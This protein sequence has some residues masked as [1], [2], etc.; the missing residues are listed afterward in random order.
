MNKNRYRIIFNRARGLMMAV[1][2]IATGRGTGC[3]TPSSMCVSALP[4]SVSLARLHPLAGSI[5]LGLGL[6][7]VLNPL[8]CAQ[9]VADTTAPASQQPIVTQAANGVPLVNIQTPSAAGVSRNTY[10]QFDVGSQGVILN[11]ARV[12]TQTQLGGWIQGNPYLPGSSAR[13]ILNEVNSA[14]PSQLLGYI[15]IGGN[16]AQVVIANPAGVTCDGCG[17]INA[18]R[19]TLTTGTPVLNGGSLDGYRVQGGQITVQGAGLDAS[20]TD[21]TDLIARAVSVNAGIH[22]Q[23]LTVTTGSNQVNAANTLATPI[24]SSGGTV[25]AVAIDVAALGGMY[26]NKITLIGTE[27]GVGVR[28]AGQINAAS[29]N[30]SL[31]ANGLLSNSGQI[32]SSA[33]LGIS[34]VGLDNS[35]TLGAQNNA[36]LNSSAA[37]RNTGVVTAGAD[38]NASALTLDNQ[39]A[40]MNAGGVLSIHTHT[41]DNHATAGSQ[42]GIQARTVILDT[43]QINN[44]SGTLNAAD[45]LTITSAGSLD[46]T[47]GRISAGQTLNVQDTHPATPTL[48]I[49]NTLGSLIA[50]QSLRI[51]AARLGGD[52]QLLSQGDLAIQLTDDFTHS[53]TLSANGNARI[54]TRGTLTNQAAMQAGQ[55]LTVSAAAIDN[56]ASGSFSAAATTLS[57]SGTL[58]NRGLIDGGDTLVTATTLDNIGSGRIYGDHLA[59]AATTLNNTSEGGTGAVIAARTRL[60]IGVQTLSN[61][62]TA[63]LFSAGD[64]S[65]GGTLDASHQAS[66]TAAQI[67]NNGGTIEALGDVHLN[68][69][70]I[71]NTN[72][73]FTTAVAT[74]ASQNI[75]EYQGS[76]SLNRYAPNAIAWTYQDQARYLVTPEGTYINWN[77]YGY[78]HTTTE[79]RIT[80]SNPAQILAGGNLDMTAN[81]LLN[82]NSR[83]IAGGS[84]LG[85]IGTLT[86]TQVTGV[87]TVTDSGTATSAW[88]GTYCAS[89]VLGVCVNYDYNTNYSS[90]AYAPA[91]TLTSIDLTP[92]VYQQHT[93]PAG[94]AALPPAPLPAVAVGA[95]L[96]AALPNNALFHANP[97][98]AGAYLIETDPR[99]ANY[100]N[101]LSSDYLLSQLG[102]DP[103]FMQKRLGDGFYEQRLVREQVA[104]LTGRRF[105]DGY[106]SDEVQYRALLDAGVTYAHD[107]QLV[108]GVA[109]SAAQMAALTSDMVWLVAQAMTLPDG[110]IRQVLVPQLYVHVREGDLLGSGALISGNHVNFNLSG[111]LTNSGTIAGRN[112]VALS[113]ENLK[114][115]GGRISG[116]DVGLAARTDIDNLGGAISA[117]NSL[118]VVAGRDLNAASTTR[119][120]TNAQGSRTNIDRIAGL[121]VSAPAAL[122]LASAGRDVNLTGAV[123]GNSGRGGLTQLSA[124]QDV[125]LGSVTDATRQRIVWDA[126][127]YR[128]DAHHS[129]IGTV[130]Q[131]QGD[132]R[133]QA[134]ND[135]SARAASVSSAQGTIAARAGRDITLAA[136]QSGV[137]VDEAHQHSRRD[138]LNKETTA[139]RDT[140]NT[141]TAIGSSLSG[142]SVSLVAGRDVGVSGSQLGTQADMT[143]AA[144]GDINLT[145]AANTRDERHYAYSKQSGLVASGYAKRSSEETANSSQTT[146]TGSRLAS[147]SGN[148]SLAANLATNPEPNKGLIL[149]EGSQVRAD[150][151]SVDIS[152]KHIL[153]TTSEDVS[154]SDY[155]QKQSKSTWA[156]STGL[157]TGKRL[158]VSSDTQR[159]TQN[160]STLQGAAGVTLNAP[161]VIDLTAAQLAVAQG[162][163]R[164]TGGDVSIQ[165]GLNQSRAHA[166]ETHT[167]TGM[168]LRDVTH[169]FTPGE[170]MGYKSTRATD[171]AR[172]TLA[173]ATLAARNIAIQS[174]AGDV[175]LAA[176]DAR[177]DA[178]NLDA[179]NNLKLASLTTTEQHSTDLKKKDLAW[180]SVR[181][182]GALDQTTQ[183]NQLNAAQL[184][185]LA[186]NRITA[187]MGVKDSVAVLAQQPGMGWLKQLQ[188]DP[189]LASK[190]DWN[191]IE[192][193]HQS[194]NYKQQ[195]LTPAAAVVVTLVV[196]WLTAGAGSGIVGGVTGTTATTYATTTAVVQAAVTTLASKAAVSLI[197]NGGRLDATLKELGSK[198][199]LR[200][201]ATSLVT[202][203]VL[204]ELGN[205]MTIGGKTLNSV[206]LSD[207]FAAN[208]GKNLITGLTRATLNSAVAG[209][210][211]ETSIRTE[212][213]AG[214]LG[215]AS[216]QGAN[217][218]GDQAQNGALNQF[219][220]VFAHAI[221]GCMAG[222]AGAS[223][224][225]SNTST[226]SGCGAGA[227]GAAVGELSA[228][229]YGAADPAKTVAFAS[230]VSGIAGA[231]TGQGA[232][233]VSI[234]ASTGAN[235][236]QNNYLNHL[237]PSL[238]RLSEKERYEAAANGCAQGDNAACGVRNELAAL[239]RQRDVALAQ[240]CAGGNPGLC[241]D[242]K[243][244]AISMGNKVF[245]TQGGF[246]YANSPSPTLSRINTATIGV[247][248]DPRQGSFHDAA[249][250]STLDAALLASAGAGVR[251]FGTAWSALSTP[252]KLTLGGGAG[253]GFDAAGQLVKGEDYRYGQTLVAGTT[254]VLVAPFASANVLLNASLGGAV[255]A[256]NTYIN[257]AIY[258]EDVSVSRAAQAGFIF[259][260]LGTGFGKAATSVFTPFLPAR[261]GGNPIN[262]A[263]PILFQNFGKPNPYPGYI[264][265]TVEQGISNIPSFLDDKPK[266]GVKP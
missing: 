40:L 96:P 60:D 202:A 148:V 27:A 131:T 153:M 37:L 15:E 219:G 181:S 81:T 106:A 240:A 178:I 59:L 151:G 33:N 91:P 105:L 30:L 99:F 39:G 4:V 254:G 171:S 145:A 266:A 180:Q 222:A 89:R 65:I 20:Q 42:Q 98:P 152:G 165:S 47:Q 121:Y 79:T 71:D 84:L 169:T 87:R 68:A 236:A 195:G 233:G 133:L 90:A 226:G 265:T 83:I 159:V 111:D 1:A 208:V 237:R 257:N 10:S 158:G 85:S 147:A 120:Q 136:A 29:G 205:A 130:I 41:L 220:H 210:D 200:Q 118:T 198:D 196:A 168:S 93:A 76:G 260:G 88:R 26:A 182:N 8:A 244:E 235:A 262:P 192:E 144:G 19:A 143:L 256:T 62:D 72:A 112:V 239:S 139:S 95:P 258:G 134:G 218:I 113:A 207:G 108:P 104:Q 74:V 167:K 204:S 231:L 58:T 217:W 246:T 242:L 199:S 97:N 51:D 179:A 175:R 229:L 110:T 189:N 77:Q 28:N 264:G 149:I 163:I 21:Y 14:N 5:L 86:N 70:R 255:G 9:I 57:A 187:D 137:Q 250:R 35:G 122:L 156:F 214:I 69:N 80:A 140:L 248:H 212:V 115:F 16:R 227:I 172:T 193:A 114:N 50:G 238:L 11:N 61:Q 251:S 141:T 48:I 103:A 186:G 253:A 32:T 54:D 25:P 46:N 191:K 126:A 100:R 73:L 101:W 185:I 127:N 188:A 2:E 64:M 92:T 184:N 132:I 162:D 216:A 203:G 201:L 166:T 22:A 190:I 243:N 36:T 247:P 34:T 252:G 263:I 183:Y 66:G 245:V 67:I 44:T 224:S 234:A 17:F 142:H 23:Q 177:A 174:T 109:L 261:I 75:T 102:T 225:G 45:N 232:E 13:V 135:L 128:S 194:W 119:T 197:N 176:V 211:L 170:G 160:G 249:A 223:A 55:A 18:S 52:G 154:S 150:A 38:L 161:G 138:F 164:I 259:S 146:H 107:W 63:Q 31:S 3:R 53:G 43:D 230:M 173:P 125:N 215:A 123:I 221:A 206:Q 241:L 117:V 157:P 228:Q 6:A 209:T 56:R 78:T 82:D 12:N 24:A 124:G 213:V 116:A 155:S 94:G 7:I 49:G 129:E